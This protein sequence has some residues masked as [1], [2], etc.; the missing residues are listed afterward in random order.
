MIAPVFC[1]FETN[2]YQHVL[3]E[4]PMFHSLAIAVSHIVRGDFSMKVN[5]K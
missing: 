1:L 2:A 3:K 5:K 4:Q